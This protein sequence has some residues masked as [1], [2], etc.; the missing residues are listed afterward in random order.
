[1]SEL[2]CDGEYEYDST[3]PAQGGTLMLSR[4][5]T[6]IGVVAGLAIFAVWMTIV[7]NPHVVETVLGVVFA[8]VGGVWVWRKLRRGKPVRP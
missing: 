1:M 3:Q 4:Y 6:I 7:G 2:P 5:A 8:T